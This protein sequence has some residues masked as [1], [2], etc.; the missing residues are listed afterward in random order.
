MGAALCMVGVVF[1]VVGV[2]SHGV[3]SPCGYCTGWL[4]LF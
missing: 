2:A 1:R 3:S 4:L